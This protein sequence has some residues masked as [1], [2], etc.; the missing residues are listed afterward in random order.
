MR[1]TTRHGGTRVGVDA[2]LRRER[3]CHLHPVGRAWSVMW[4]IRGGVTTRWPC[5]R[6][7]RGMVGRALAAGM[8]R[9]GSA[10]GWCA[11]AV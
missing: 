11:Q 7:S 3:P 4:P 8:P 2:N 9:P 5:S 6:S 10:K 1:K